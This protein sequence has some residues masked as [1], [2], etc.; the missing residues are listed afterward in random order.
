MDKYRLT[1]KEAPNP[2]SILWE[3]LECSKLESMG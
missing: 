2:S 1:A 3:N